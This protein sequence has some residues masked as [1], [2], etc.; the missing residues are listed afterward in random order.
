MREGS[1]GGMHVARQN[2]DI[3]VLERPIRPQRD[4]DRLFADIRAIGGSV[5]GWADD[6]E[7]D[8][9]FGAA[10]L[11]K[12][13]MGCQSPAHGLDFAPYPQGNTTEIVAR[14]S[15]SWA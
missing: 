6:A 8:F 5:G 1:S 15:H 13:R 9:G 10:I 4:L 7:P 12:G 11:T 14:K 3:A 2:A